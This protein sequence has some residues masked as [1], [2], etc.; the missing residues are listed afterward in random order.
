KSGPLCSCEVSKNLG[1]FLKNNN[2]KE[3][4]PY[5][6]RIALSP[7]LW[8]TWRAQ[9][10]IVHVPDCRCRSSGKPKLLQCGACRVVR[11]CSK[12]CQRADWGTHKH[13]CKTLGRRSV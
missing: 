11:Y 6:T 13:I 5:A 2:W 8:H 3:M 1:P 9:N 7:V 4:V 12:D 10:N